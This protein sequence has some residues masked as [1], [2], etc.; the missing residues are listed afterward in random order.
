MINVVDIDTMMIRTIC[1]VPIR[2]HPYMYRDRPISI[3]RSY[4]SKFHVDQNSTTT[5]AHVGIPTRKSKNVISKCFSSISA[6]GIPD[7]KALDRV[8][9]SNLHSGT[10]ILRNPEGWVLRPPFFGNLSNLNIL[11]LVK[12]K[13]NENSVPESDHHPI[14]M[15]IWMN[16][17]NQFEVWELSGPTWSVLKMTTLSWK[18][19]G[20]HWKHCDPNLEVVKRSL[21]MLQ[22]PVSNWCW[23]SSMTLD[24]NSKVAPTS[25][26]S[27]RQKGGAF[28]T[29]PKRSIQDPLSTTVSY[30]TFL[31]IGICSVQDSPHQSQPCENFP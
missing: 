9:W 30:Q 2:I 31:T 1:T 15:F 18:A 29:F 20:K 8:C 23:K 11:H 12:K 22:D 4:I 5:T 25:Y 24:S 17:I 16:S 3:C 14:I 7:E 10:S 13:N 6:T 19:A 28:F 21:Q 27:T 26:Q